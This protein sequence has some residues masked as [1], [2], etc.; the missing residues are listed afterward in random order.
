MFST[1][2]NTIQ[3]LRDEIAS[4]KKEN[5]TLKDEIKSPVEDMLA[6]IATRIESDKVLKDE[7]KT[8]KKKN[9][10]LKKKHKAD[11]LVAYAAAAEVFQG[12]IAKKNKTLKKKN[13]TLKKWT[14]QC[15]GWRDENETLKEKIKTLIDDANDAEQ[16][17]VLCDEENETLKK[18]NK[19]LKCYFEAADAE[20]GRGAKFINELKDE[21]ETLKKK[22]YYAVETLKE[23]IKTLKE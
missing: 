18:E 22:H 9:K 14:N 3:A 20:C 13:K 21:M 17:A 5:K 10:T 16:N 23:K 6:L 1:R 12:E 4:L 7:I 11:L 8:L 2:S 19:M 15:V